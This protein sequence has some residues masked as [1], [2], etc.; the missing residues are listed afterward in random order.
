LTD[1]RAGTARSRRPAVKPGSR[2]YTVYEYAMLTAGALLMALSFNLF[3]APHR[4]ASGGVAGISILLRHTFGWE[5]A[6]VQ[7]ALNVPLFLLGWKL[8]G[9]SASW[10]TAAGT[11][12]LPLFVY[13]T[14]DVGTPTD[15]PLLSSVF[16]GVLTG[17]GLGIVF[18]S[19]GTT[20]GLSILAKILHKY[21]GLSYGLST[22]LLD[23]LVIAAAGLVFAPELALYAL[24]SLFVTSKTIDIVQLG[25]SASKV[26]FIISRET[27]ALERAILHE[28]DRGVTRIPAYGGYTGAERPVLMVVIGT[29]EVARLKEKVRHI[30]PSSFVWISDTHEVLGEG[31][32][33]NMD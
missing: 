11:L 24:L 20:G 30:D 7:W 32:R 12:L 14:R 22:A 8:F 27:E 4:L 6:Y 9:G 13:W 15:D 18:R 3:L 26:A 1:T 31:F 25:W 17:A 28:L 5:P 16:G 10:K 19:R 29:S 23:G 2:A 33:R 21:A